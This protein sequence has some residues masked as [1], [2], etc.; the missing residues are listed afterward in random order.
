MCKSPVARRKSTSE[1]VQEGQCGW[2]GLACGAE[3]RRWAKARCLSD[4][5]SV[6]IFIL[7]CG[8]STCQH[9]GLVQ[10]ASAVGTQAAASRAGQAG[11]SVAQG[12]KQN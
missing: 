7:S 3:D 10:A 2:H 12:Q 4:L 9:Q 6:T 1:D 11:P 8:C 5:I